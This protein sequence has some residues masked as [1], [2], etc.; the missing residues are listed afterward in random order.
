MT[1]EDRVARSIRRRHG[2]VILRS[3][4][5]LLGSTAQVGRVLAKMVGDGRLVRVSKGVYCK[6]RVNKWTGKLA[7]AA[8]FE[9][10]AAETFRKLRIE[11]SPGRLAREFNS[12]KT[13][14]IPVDG[15]VCT[16][17]RRIRRKIQVGSRIVNYEN[18]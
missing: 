9:V 8:P 16:G 1:I 5:A 13:T 2:F 14:Q 17:R 7:P 4:V 10:I 6:T 3:E 11:V 12:G 15:A 18:S